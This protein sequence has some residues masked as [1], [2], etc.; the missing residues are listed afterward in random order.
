MDTPTYTVEVDGNVKQTGTPDQA[1]RWVA[2]AEVA[3]R[4]VRYDVSA[5]T[6]PVKQQRLARLRERI[7][8]HKKWLARAAEVD[9]IA[10][11]D[12]ALWDR[13]GEEGKDLEKRDEDLWNRL[14][15]DS[16]DL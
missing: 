16:F 10:D 11:N 6:A 9:E 2:E 4:Q 12:S 15:K 1:A 7:E 13:T 5:M 14:K 3:R 8:E